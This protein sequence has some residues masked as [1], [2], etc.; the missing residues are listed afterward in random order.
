MSDNQ[1]TPRLLPTKPRR[2]SGGEPVPSV[3][4]LPRKPFAPGNSLPRPP[5]H[6]AHAVERRLWNALIASYDLADAASLAL[7][8]TAMDSHARARRCRDQI[9]AE[10]ETVRDKWGQLRA[11]PLIGAEKDARN[12]WLQAMKALRLDLGPAA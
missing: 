1:S 5:K 6:L 9:N 12:G 2:T 4:D 10:G 11:H 8:G 7:L 3:R